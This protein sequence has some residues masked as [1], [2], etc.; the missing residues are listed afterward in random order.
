MDADRP[1]YLDHHAT[2]PCDPRVI[3][4]MTPYFGVHFGNPSERSHRWGQEAD[5]AVEAA[6]IDVA[7]LASATV[8]ACATSHPSG[9]AFSSSQVRWRMDPDHTPFTRGTA[10]QNPSSC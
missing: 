9:T 2:T 10:H 1:I 7:R 3:E 5:R 4:A 8:V 6:R